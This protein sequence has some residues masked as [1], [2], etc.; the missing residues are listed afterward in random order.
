MEGKRAE[1]EEAGR[2]GTGTRKQFGLPAARDVLKKRSA[3]N[4]T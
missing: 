4:S 1:G 2:V 3:L